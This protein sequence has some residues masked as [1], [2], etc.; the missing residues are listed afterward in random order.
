MVVSAVTIERSPEIEHL[1]IA[2]GEEVDRVEL[3]YRE[4]PLPHLVEEREVLVG[5]RRSTS[6]VT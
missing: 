2:A 5:R 4:V 6:V 3:R 1:E